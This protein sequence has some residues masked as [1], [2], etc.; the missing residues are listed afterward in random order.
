MKN[1]ILLLSAASVFALTGCHGIKKVEFSE[2]QKE[3]LALKDKEIPTVKEVTIKGKLADEKYSFKVT[4]ENVLDL[5]MKELAVSAMVSALTIYETAL[6][7]GE[8]TS[9]YVGLGFKVKS[10]EGVMEFNKYGYLTLL[11]GEI[12]K[13]AVNLSVSYKYSK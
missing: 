2:Y 10:D 13:Q 3:V 1:K 4:E 8:G 9:Y 7:E 12:E 6:V 5:S 11:K